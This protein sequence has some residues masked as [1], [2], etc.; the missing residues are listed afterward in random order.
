MEITKLLE[1]I[2]VLNLDTPAE[3]NTVDTEDEFIGKYCV[4]RTYS[5]GVH[6]GTIKRRVGNK[7]V[8]ENSR[9]LWRWQTANN[10]ISL[11]EIA[12]FG[13]NPTG[14]RICCEVPLK[15]LEPIEIILCSG[16]ARQ[17]IEKADVYIAK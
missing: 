17:S 1:L 9:N 11:S 12:V 6:A 5:A 3:T 13:I 15:E 2:K 14:S 4:I 7:V 16:T 10:G 8:L